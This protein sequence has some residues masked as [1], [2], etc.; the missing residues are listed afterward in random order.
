[1]ALDGQMDGWMDG[2]TVRRTVKAATICSPFWEQK[3]HGHGFYSN[4]KQVKNLGQFFRNVVIKIRCAKTAKYNYLAI[5]KCIHHDNEAFCFRFL[6]Q[7]H[8]GYIT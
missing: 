3:N 2:Q 6:L 5:V 7:R 4:A 8:L 1:M